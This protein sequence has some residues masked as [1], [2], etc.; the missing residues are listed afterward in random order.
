MASETEKQQGFDLAD[1][2]IKFNYKEFVNVKKLNLMGE[3]EKWLIENPNGGT[4]K[5]EKDK[6]EDEGYENET[7]KIALNEKA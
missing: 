4:F 3:F 7:F 2:L 6:F 1:Y 5:F